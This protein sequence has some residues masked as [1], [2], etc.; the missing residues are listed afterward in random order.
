MGYYICHMKSFWFSFFLIVAFVSSCG[1]KHTFSDYRSVD[2]LKWSSMDT[3]KFDFDLPANKKYSLSLSARHR[4]DYE[5]SNLWVKVF[6]KG[7]QTDTAFRYEMQ[8][9]NAEGRP[10]G[11][12]SGSTCTQTIPVK[13]IKNL[14]QGHYELQVVQLMR[15]D[16]LEGIQ[17]IGVIVDQP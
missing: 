12:C 8:L 4:K 3:V 1:E 7:P 5:F 13:S 14:N 15:T 11:E 10:F 9:F 17:D 6:L 2:K 16:P